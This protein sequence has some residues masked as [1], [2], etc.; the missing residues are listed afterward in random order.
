MSR[1]VSKTCTGLRAVYYWDIPSVTARNVNESF[2]FVVEISTF[3]KFP[4]SGLDSVLSSSFML[5]Q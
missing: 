2:V 1:L 4:N 3:Q 5:G